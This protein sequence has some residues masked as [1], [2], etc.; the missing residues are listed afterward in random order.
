MSILTITNG[1]HANSEE[2]VQLL[3][4][5]LDCRIISDADILEL[6]HQ[7]HDISLTT[8]QK[9]LESRQIA[10]N[11]FT[12]EREKCL[13]AMKKTLSDFVSEGNCILHGLIGHMIPKSVTHVMRVLIIAEKAQRI[14]NGM[15]KK[16]LS[17]KE[18]TREIELS[19]KHAT[20]WTSG[21][22]HQKAW[23]ESLYDIVIP[24]AK[25]D[26]TEAV[27]LVSKHLKKIPFT[28]EDLIQ[29][30]IFDFKVTA[31][32]ELALS[33]IGQGLLV[34]SSKGNVVVTI[35]KKVM[36][37][38]KFQQKIIQTA[39]A[40]PGVVSVETKIGHNY[41]KGNIIHNYEFETPLRILLV[42]DEK[43][44]VQTLSERL[45]MRQFTNEIAYNGQQALDFTNEEDT[46]VILL[47]LK[48]PGIDGFEV[49]KTIK[50]TKPHI[51]VI[52]LTG[53]GSEADRET[54]MNLGAFAY[55]QK[56]ADI[57]LITQT[58]KKAYEKIEAAKA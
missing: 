47:D 49:L 57:D 6:T 12:H 29:Q 11:D 58:M 14:K 3:G 44:F 54:C 25:L 4:K 9:V 20:L 32:V 19:D 38:T 22:F 5:K 50:E 52:I 56:P 27:D 51:E 15:A 13:S 48:M 36:L 10:F 39:Q 37:L 53:H 8:L 28:L 21:L 43:E 23:D 16:G 30:E 46:E 42:D 41:Y 31:D 1:L 17:E 34:E 24:S 26:K 35:D 18:I 33:Q 7:S 2:I 55:L 40:V 45:K